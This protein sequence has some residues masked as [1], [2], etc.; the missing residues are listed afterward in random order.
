MLGFTKNL[1]ISLGVV[2]PALASPLQPRTSTSVAQLAL[3]K[4]LEDASPILGNYVNFGSNS[5]T[6]NWMKSYSDSTQIVHM[7]IPGT[8][9]SATWNYSQATQDSMA[10]VAALNGL[11]AYPPEVFRCQ[12]SS[13][14]TML[15]SG[16]RVLDLRYAFDP[17]NTT[18]IFYH[19]QALLSET[20]TLADLMFGFYK[21]LDDHP[22]EALFLSFQYEGSTAVYAANNADVQLNLFNILTSPAAQNYILQT[23]DELG[24]LGQARGKITLFRRFDMDQLPSSYEDALPGL[25]F[26]PSLWTDNDP[27]IVLTYNTQKNL[28]A[29]I[30]DYYE[31][32]SPTGTTAS[33]NIGLKYNATSSHILKATTQYPDSLFWT[34]ASSEFVSNVPADTPRIMATGNGTVLTPEGGV[35]QQLVPFLESLKGKRA[36]RLPQRHHPPGNFIL[37]ANNY[38]Q[39]FFFLHFADVSGSLA[40]TSPTSVSSALQAASESILTAL[41]LLEESNF[42]TSTSSS[43]SSKEIEASDTENQHQ[44]QEGEASSHR[45]KFRGRSTARL[46]TPGKPCNTLTNTLTH[47]TIQYPTPSQP[48]NHHL[49]TIYLPY[50]RHSHT[51]QRALLGK[52]P[53]TKPHPQHLQ[54]KQHTNMSH[55]PLRPSPG[56]RNNHPLHTHLP[57]HLHNSLAD[58]AVDYSESWMDALICDCEGEEVTP[59][60]NERE[61]FLTFRVANERQRLR[62]RPH[63]DKMIVRGPFPAFYILSLGSPFPTLITVGYTVLIKLLQRGLVFATSRA[64]MRGEKKKSG[65]GRY[66]IEWRFQT[67]GDKWEV[68][69]RGVV[70]GRYKTSSYATLELVVTDASELY[71]SRSLLFIP[72]EKHMKVLDSGGACICSRPQFGKLQN[73]TSSSFILFEMRLTNTFLAAGMSASVLATPLLINGC[74]WEPWQPVPT[75]CLPHGP[76]ATST[77]SAQPT[78]TTTASGKFK[79]FGVNQSG[80]EFAPTVLPGK[81]N[82]D[83]SWPSTESI[84]TLMGKGMNTFRIPFLMERIAQGTMTAPLDATYLAALENVVSFITAKGGYAIVDAHNYGRYN[85]ILFT[86]TSDFKTF[87]T[88]V[89]TEFAKNDKVIFDCNNE[90][91]NEDSDGTYKNLVALNQACIDGVRAAGATTQYIFIE[92]SDWDGAWHLNTDGG[93]DALLALTDPSDKIIFELHQYLDDGT[94]THEECTSSTIGAE[95]ISN[96]TAWLKANKRTAVLGEYAGGNNTVCTSA[97]E[98]MLDAMTQDSEVWLGALWWGGGARW[99]SDYVFNFEPPTGS[100]YVYYMDILEKYI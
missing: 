98:G 96:A 62:T 4:V 15:N 58:I 64:V 47:L 46:A 1:L 84:G 65:D 68:L 49:H 6:A 34:W 71:D 79:W 51:T 69:S 31:T 29:Y 33:Y 52:Q 60:M 99:A 40:L 87:W 50:Y 100:Q 53:A 14:I 42:N 22:S 61:N 19:S 21:W 10:H 77:G 38:L 72:H 35:N 88:N 3:Q 67:L 86:S 18:L 55:L 36:H 56:G 95:R 94:G 11:T 41:L 63:I 20:G 27:N 23:K 81:L 93:G 90:W 89:A 16:I 32:D 28:T 57:P 85:N 80:A 70:I 39:Y 12:N 83:Y 8:H 78:T 43:S 25:H 82:D 97:V 48:R 91:N 75:S 30:E 24:T 9:D 76:K 66:G 92:S 44:S 7:N 13:I 74:T 59:F 37:R 73:A 5:K 26:S 45:L 2:I 54:H 17:T